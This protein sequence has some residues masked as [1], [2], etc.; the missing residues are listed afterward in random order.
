MMVDRSKR[1]LRKQVPDED[2]AMKKHGTAKKREPLAGSM[3]V[4]SPKEAVDCGE[5][6]DVRICVTK[7]EVP[8]SNIGVKQPHGRNR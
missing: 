4:A 6:K 5:G 2:D 3:I 8:S 7:M 1:R